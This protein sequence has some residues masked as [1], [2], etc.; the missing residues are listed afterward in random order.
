MTLL[1]V[2]GL[3][4]GYGAAE[5]VHG[6]D[7]HVAAGE[8]V[9]VLGPNGAGKSTMLKAIAGAAPVTGG[10]VVVDGT[11]VAGAGA[12]TIAARGAA[13][14]PQER[15]IFRSLTVRENLDLGGWLV[16]GEIAA[17]R[18]AVLDLLP[19]LRRLTGRVAGRLSGG[20][21]QVLAV[22]MALMVS[23]RLLLV[24][25][26]TAGL[27]PA[28]VG[29]LLALLR[30]LAEGGIAVLLVEQNARAA[31]GCSDRAM[32]LVDGRIAFSGGTD[33]L[34]AAPDLGALFLGAAA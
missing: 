5:V 32:I 20:E 22:G 12:A 13:Y 21:R 1:R 30:R 28:L 6:V 8:M 19:E 3:R 7:L 4:A 29:R 9:A 31:I 24:D 33:E 16:R 14:V 23:P 2:T 26:P 25:E 15:N 17:R 34:L 27:S 11:N 18:A 10:E